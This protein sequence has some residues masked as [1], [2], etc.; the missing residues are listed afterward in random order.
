MPNVDQLEQNAETHRAEL[1]DQISALAS[2][3]NP[4]ANAK[5]AVGQTADIGQTLAKAVLD[6]TKNQ[7]AG[8]TMIGIGAA[9]IALN[10]GKKP[11][12]RL[13]SYDEMGSHDDRIA[14][15]DRQMKARAQVK[16]G[17]FAASQSA[18]TLRKSLDKGLDRL[19]PEARARV[20]EARLK[21]IDAQ[22]KLERQA[23]RTSKQAQ[24]AHQ[25]QPF[26]T[27]AIVAGVGAIIGALLPSTKAEADLMGATR[28]NMMRD[29]EAVLRDE[30]SKIEQQGKAAVESSIREARAE[31]SDAHQPA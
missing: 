11:E 4:E 25:S 21:V 18:S 30:F 5:R 15:A 23:R 16:S 31:F 6:G 2:S 14:R 19:S 10:T 22:E 24:E 28:D 12:P 1:T 7:P 13:T 8:L 3:V 9:M 20:T 17:R 26:L 27:G 29:A